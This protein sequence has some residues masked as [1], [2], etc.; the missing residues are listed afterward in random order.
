M[1]CLYTNRYAPAISHHKAIQKL[2]CVAKNEMYRYLSL[3]VYVAVV[4][5][6][7]FNLH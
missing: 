3:L 4:D 6:P 1:I 7:R 5:L 2:D